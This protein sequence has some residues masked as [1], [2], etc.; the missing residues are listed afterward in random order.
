MEV[1]GAKAAEATAKKQAL[2]REMLE[3]VGDKWTL[4]VIEELG[5]GGKMRFTR[6]R[7]QIGGV[8]QKMLTKTLRR[9]ECDGLVTRRVYPVVPPRVEY[10]LT[11][12]GAALLPIIEEMRR[13]GRGYLTD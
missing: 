3:R 10:E 2:V 8:T 9:L 6:L 11:E 12:K 1:R 5:S 7:D 4:L 13:F